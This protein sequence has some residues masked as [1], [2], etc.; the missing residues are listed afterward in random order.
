MPKQPP[1]PP[2]TPPVDQPPQPTAATPE[3]ATTVR[4][5]TAPKRTTRESLEALGIRVLP[6]SGR[7]YTLLGASGYQKAKTKTETQE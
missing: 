2:P 1:Q 6:A 4:N 3:Q 5:A 7:S